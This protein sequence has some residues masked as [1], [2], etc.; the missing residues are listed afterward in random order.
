MS[1]LAGFSLSGCTVETGLAKTGVKKPDTD[2]R[3][4]E[5]QDKTRDAPSAAEEF[6][7]VCAWCSQLYLVFYCQVTSG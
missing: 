4:R 3:K 2:K 5:G 6:T 1:L 7:A